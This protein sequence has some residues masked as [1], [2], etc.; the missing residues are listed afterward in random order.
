MT[1]VAEYKNFS[2]EALQQEYA[3]LF[4]SYMYYMAAEGNWAS[5]AQERNEVS[6]EFY[7]CQ[8]EMKE[9]GLEV[10]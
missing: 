4:R 8:R 7:A 10:Y 3:R 9:R 1:K 6:Q 5:E 2:N